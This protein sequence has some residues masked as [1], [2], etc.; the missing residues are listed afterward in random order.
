[1]KKTSRFKKM[2]EFLGKM[3]AP[4]DCQGYPEI[5]GKRYIFKNKECFIWNFIRPIF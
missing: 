2:H 3:L 4:L 1:M 5:N